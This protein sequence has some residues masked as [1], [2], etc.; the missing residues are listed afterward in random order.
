MAAVTFQPFGTTVEAAE[1]E[2]LFDAGR[3][4]GVPIPTACVGKASCGLC[5]VKI[6]DGEAHL[7]PQNA[8]EKRHLGNTYFI[9][10]LRLSCQARIVPGGGQ[11][12]VELPDAARR[13]ALTKG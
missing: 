9:S 13:Q 2:S 7:S 10:K 4:A 5:R 6:L 11:V 3:R 12:V 8:E 1:G